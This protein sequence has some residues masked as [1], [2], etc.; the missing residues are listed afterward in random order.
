[1][2]YLIIHVLYLLHWEFLNTIIDKEQAKKKLNILHSQQ[3]RDNSRPKL[4]LP[5]EKCT[6]HI[7]DE[8]CKNIKI[9]SHIKKTLITIIHTKEIRK[10]QEQKGKFNRGTHNMVDWEAGRKS[11]NN[12]ISNQQQKWL[13]NG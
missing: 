9:S 10:Y 3:R 8:Q 1:M 7:L 2:I 12:N 4:L 5:Y 11:C 6:V 13:E